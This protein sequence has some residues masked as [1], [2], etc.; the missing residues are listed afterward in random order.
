MVLARTVK[1]SEEIGEL[2]EQ[3]LAYS[4]LQRKTKGDFDDKKLCEEFAD[5]LISTLL[6]A[7][8]VNIDVENALKDKINKIDG[9]YWFYNSL[10]VYK[11]VTCVMAQY[12]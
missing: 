4:G 9:R 8:Y 11:V 12:I 1:L 3:I 10:K 7:K 6:I 2:S 5:V